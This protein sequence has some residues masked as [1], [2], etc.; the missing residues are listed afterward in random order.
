MKASSFL[1]C[2][3]RNKISGLVTTTALMSEMDGDDGQV[4]G[5]PLQSYN[6]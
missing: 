1:P 5:R 2:I 6:R 3:G 4:K